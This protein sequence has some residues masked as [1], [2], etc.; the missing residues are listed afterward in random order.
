M[1]ATKTNKLVLSLTGIL[2][3]ALGMLVSSAATKQI[4]NFITSGSVANSK[5]TLQLGKD[6]IMGTSKVLP[7]CSTTFVAV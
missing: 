1:F 7:G 2:G 6:K 5:L 3:I 4:P